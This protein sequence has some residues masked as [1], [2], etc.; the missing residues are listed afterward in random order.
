M[1]KAVYK[2]VGE[3][4]C[5]YFKTER[6]DFSLAVEGLSDDGRVSVGGVFAELVSGRGKIDMTD[7]P[8]GIYSIY[9]HT[10]EKSVILGKIEKSA[11]LIRRVITEEDFD[12]ALAAIAEISEKLSSVENRVAALDEKVFESV[13]F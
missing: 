6:G 4:I 8:D 11:S 7:V 5:I 10:K 3:Y 12:R 1:S 9:L 13:I 2:N